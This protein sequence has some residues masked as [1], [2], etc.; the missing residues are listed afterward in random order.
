MACAGIE[1]TRW[2]GAQNAKIQ[3]CGY[4][5]ITFITIVDT[6]HVVITNHMTLLVFDTGA[7]ARL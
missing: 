5:T 7:R 1:F 6:T 4:I 3:P 2:P